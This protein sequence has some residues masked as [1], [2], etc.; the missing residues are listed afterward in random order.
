MAVREEE[1]DLLPSPGRDWLHQA[2]IRLIL[3]WPEEL[4]WFRGRGKRANQRGAQPARPV[5]LW[6]KATW[7]GVLRQCRA[8]SYNG[9]RGNAAKAPIPACFRE[10]R[11]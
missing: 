4:L 7:V 3:P 10:H 1:T 8:A 9:T 11:I 2:V 5:A 6:K